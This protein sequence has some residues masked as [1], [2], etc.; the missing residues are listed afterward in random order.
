MHG[1]SAAPGARWTTESRC[2]RSTPR[3]KPEALDLLQLHCPHPGVYD[4]P[5]VF[6]MVDD[7]V[8]AGKVVDEDSAHMPNVEEPEKSQRSLIELGRRFCS[9]G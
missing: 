7:L 2:A 8:R 1:P 5:E 4:R 3:W 6:G 9:E